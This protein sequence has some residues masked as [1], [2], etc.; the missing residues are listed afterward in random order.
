MQILC[1]QQIAEAML[2]LPTLES[3]GLIQR[4]TLQKAW[5]GKEKRLYDEKRKTE[6]EGGHNK[7]IEEYIEYRMYR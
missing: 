1:K 5:D 6:K 7:Y 3:G 2:G 4:P